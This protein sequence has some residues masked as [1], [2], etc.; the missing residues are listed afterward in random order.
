MTLNYI[1]HSAT[2]CP[3]AVV[4]STV[5]SASVCPGVGITFTF[6]FILYSS[7]K[8]IKKTVQNY[9]SKH[10]LV[11]YDYCYLYQMDGYNIHL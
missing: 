11:Y 6:S 1:P 4:T 10:N 5:T 3:P 8:K 7:P 2:L 9:K